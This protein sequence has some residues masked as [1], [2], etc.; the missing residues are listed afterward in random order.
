MFEIHPSDLVTI[1]L[2]VAL[3]GLRARTYKNSTL[4]FNLARVFILANPHVAALINPPWRGIAEPMWSPVQIRHR[5]AYYDAFF[6]EALMDYGASGLA[7]PAE[8][9]KARAATEAMIRFCLETSREEVLEH[10][11]KTSLTGPLSRQLDYTTASDAVSTDFI[12]SR[13]ASVID[14]NAAIVDGDSAILYVWYD[15][16]FGYSCQVLRTV[17]YVSGVEY[18][19]LPR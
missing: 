8:A 9:A 14:G 2:L 18:P 17:Q 13:A 3:E 16:E 4:L 19:T 5:S 7:G 6:A 11:R 12:G 1:A 15:N 10:L